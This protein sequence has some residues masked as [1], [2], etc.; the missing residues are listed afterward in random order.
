VVKSVNENTALDLPPPKNHIV[1]DNLEPPVNIKVGEF[2]EIFD[3]N[4]N[5][6]KTQIIK[7][8]KTG[9]SIKVKLND[10]TE[11]IISLDPKAGAFQNIRN[12]NYVIRYGAENNT[13]GKSLSQLTKEQINETREILE[14]RKKEFEDG[15]GLA[16]EYAGVLNCSILTCLAVFFLLVFLILL[17][18]LLW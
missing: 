9:K 2:T 5:V 8:S 17:L 4:G 16:L 12:P 7:V 3:V 14:E 11:R 15:V 13:Q 6:I 1:S 10:G 18:E